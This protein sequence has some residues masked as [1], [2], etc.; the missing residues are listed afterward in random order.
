VAHVLLRPYLRRDLGT[1]VNLE[2]LAK[3]GR[4]RDALGVSRPAWKILRV[5]AIS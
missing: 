3:P 4:S 2:A 5:L 1:Y